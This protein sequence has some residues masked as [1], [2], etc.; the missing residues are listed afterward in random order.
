MYIIY[1]YILQDITEFHEQ[2][3]DFHGDQASGVRLAEVAAS[4]APG[5]RD[6][7]VEA[8]RGAGD[9]HGFEAKNTTI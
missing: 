4:V 5:S 7:L 8:L 3:P 6:F 2:I 9:G 1:I